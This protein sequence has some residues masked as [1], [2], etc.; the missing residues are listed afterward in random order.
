MVSNCAFILLYQ[1]CF[2]FLPLWCTLLFTLVLMYIAYNDCTSRSRVFSCSHSLDDWVY[3]SFFSFWIVYLAWFTLTGFAILL[4]G[5]ARSLY[6]S[7]S[8]LILSG[9]GLQI[10]DVSCLWRRPVDLVLLSEAGYDR[11][12]RRSLVTAHF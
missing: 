12:L 5:I 11:I 10:S 1:F 8:N 7:L 6:I 9:N 2:V 3:R 4:P